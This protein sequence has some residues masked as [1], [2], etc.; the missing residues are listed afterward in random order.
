MTTQRTSANVVME[1]RS[2]IRQIFQIPMIRE[3]MKIEGSG[4]TVNMIGPIHI[5]NHNQATGEL[6]DTGADA[7]ICFPEQK[8]GPLLLRG[9]S[10]VELDDKTVKNFD[11]VYNSLPD[12]KLDATVRLVT[13]AAFKR[14]KNCKGVAAALDC[15]VYKA[16]SLMDKYG[17]SS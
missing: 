13:E 1:Q 11:R 17:L 10:S 2:D 8:E 6:E 5:V 7:I 3:M 15:S 12:P 4:V 16:K 14:T 9:V